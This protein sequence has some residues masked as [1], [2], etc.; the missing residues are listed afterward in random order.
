MER[1]RGSLAA[2][3]V[4]RSGVAVTLVPLDATNQAPITTAF[5]ERLAG[6]QVTP[7]AAFCG[8]VLTQLRDAI[9]SGGYS[10]WDPFAAAVLTDESLGSFSSRALA[11]VTDE[12]PDSG[13][14]S[15]SQNGSVARFATS[16][17]LHRFE[18]LFL[19]TINGRAR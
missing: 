17:D 10:F 15:A 5:A 6:D 9:A 11:V 13:R 16:A 4:L 1:V 14:V 19:D 2:D 12:G 3:I 18:Q 8:A 7:Q